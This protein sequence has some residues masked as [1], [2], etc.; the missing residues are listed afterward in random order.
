VS[1]GIEAL[2]FFPVHYRPVTKNRHLRRWAPCYAGLV[3]LPQTAESFPEAVRPLA[4]S[5]LAATAEAE[6]LASHLNRR[7][8]YWRPAADSWSIGE[9]LHHLAVTNGTYTRRIERVLAAARPQPARAPLTYGLFGNWFVRFMEPPVRRKVQAPAV[10]LPPPEDPDFDPLN[11]FHES[12]D[13]LL[14]LLVR[15]A[16]Y[17]LQKIKVRSPASKLIRF[18]LAAA[19][20]I[21]AAHERRHLWQARRALE[22][23]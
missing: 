13:R 17:D 2:E 7:E 20:A 16:D 10:F 8:L 22:Q 9:C 15:A 4:A 3:N 18:N 5:F 21:L 11:A 6:S 23:Q 14:D 19:F 12:Q 1:R